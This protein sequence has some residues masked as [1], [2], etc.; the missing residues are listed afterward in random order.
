MRKAARGL[1]AARL[2]TPARPS[3]VPDEDSIPGLH[4]GIQKQSP[5]ELSLGRALFLN[6]GGG[7]GN[8]TRIF[9]RKKTMKTTAY[10]NGAAAGANSVR[11]DIYRRACWRDLHY[12]PLRARPRPATG[13]TQARAPCETPTGRKTRKK[14][15]DQQLL[16]II[17]FP[18]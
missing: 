3:S 12:F 10:H 2:E 18:N 17:V 9:L 5:T 11:S 13:A 14:Y 4:A 1:A 7:G 15:N 16:V 6:T 8:R